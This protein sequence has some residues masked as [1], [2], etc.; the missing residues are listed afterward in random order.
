MKLEKKLH[1][2]TPNKKKIAIKKMWVRI[3]I[4]KIN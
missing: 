4:K 1:K 3:E 2:R